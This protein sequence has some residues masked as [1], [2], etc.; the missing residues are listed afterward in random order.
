MPSAVVL[1]ID[2]LGAKH[3]GPYGNTWIETPAFNRL[4]TDSLLLDGLYASQPDQQQTCERW[5]GY[6]PDGL[7]KTLNEHGIHTQL[8]SDEPELFDYPAA[9]PFAQQ[10]KLEPPQGVHLAHEWD[11]THTANF[12]AQAI[13]AI[14][15][16]PPNHLL[17]LHSRGFQNP[18]DA[19]YG[20][21]QQFVDEDDPDATG[22]S[23]VPSLQLDAD[24]DPDTLHEIQCAFAG[25]VVLV[26]QCLAVLQS[27][28]RDIAKQQDVLFMVSATRGFPLGEHL[29]VGYQPTDLLYHEQL[30]VPALIRYPNGEMAMKR[31]GNLAEFHD[32]GECLG[33]WLL[34]NRPS[35][36]WNQ[37][38][39]SVCRAGDRY[40]LRTPAWHIKFNQLSNDREQDLKTAELYL[41]PDDQNEVNDVSDR[42]EPVVDAGREFLLAAE[43]SEDVRAVPEI[44]LDP[45]E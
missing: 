21:R 37:R 25:Q 33:R 45:L 23:Q 6:G 12:F 44:L 3:L 10:D 29:Q 22:S 16:A 9:A 42:C 17:W 19:P 30:A 35:T 34:Q 43:T 27:V 20:Y 26:D 2:G 11:E 5:W 8:L 32:L 15:N 7:M 24:Y 36:D 39:Y 1:A 38:Q 14:E 13:Q 40:L 28:I 4:A 18:W 41:K 31:R